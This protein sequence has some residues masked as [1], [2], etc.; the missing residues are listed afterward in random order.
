MAGQ[1]QPTNLVLLKGKKHFTKAELEERRKNEISAPSDNIEPPEYLTQKQA[2]KFIDIA[3][4][5][6][7]V[8]IM[9]NLDCDA[10]ARYIQSEEKYLKYDKL[11]SQMLRKA[12]T[13][14]KAAA[15]VI[16]LEKFENL[17]D[18]AL[19]QCRNAAADLGLTISSRCK[20]VV[21]KLPEPPKE[22]KFGKFRSDTG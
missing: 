20:L 12:N 18:K 19:K 9:G 6:L 1:R 10:L 2:Q 8:E 7:R 22:N 4:E 13:A 16:V 17:R 14:E 15:L 5:L 3:C 21:P 11:V